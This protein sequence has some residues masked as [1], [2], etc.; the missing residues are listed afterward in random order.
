MLRG[1]GPGV[2]QPI[3]TLIQAMR[4]I[5]RHV[6]PAGH[7]ELSCCPYYCIFSNSNPFFHRD[8]CFGIEPTRCIRVIRF[9]PVT[10]KHAF[11]MTQRHRQAVCR[12]SIN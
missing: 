10:K 2:N 12:P 5:P 3:I 11:L 1:D 9:L 6:L 8:L 4:Q 7:G